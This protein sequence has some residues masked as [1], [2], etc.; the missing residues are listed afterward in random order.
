MFLDQNVW[1]RAHGRAN[2]K[3][4]AHN[5]LKYACAQTFV[6]STQCA[7]NLTYLT[8]SYWILHTL[9]YIWC[10]AVHLRSLPCAM[11]GSQRAQHST[12]QHSTAQ[13]IVFEQ[14][15]GA[16]DS[17]APVFNS[18][19]KLAQYWYTAWNDTPVSRSALTSFYTA[20]PIV[21]TTY[22]QREWDLF[23]TLSNNIKIELCQTWMTSHMQSFMLHVELQNFLNVAASPMKNPQSSAR[24]I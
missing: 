15:P 23:K 13:V 22:L 1:C 2:E 20:E 24:K 3:K 8:C 5:A 12:A 17:W 7:H 11:R 19:P 18:L 16:G 10:H 21:V 14:R 9:S 4:A 6:A